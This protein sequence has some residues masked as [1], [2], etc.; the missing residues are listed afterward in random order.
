M[1]KLYHGRVSV[2]PR[3]GGIPTGRA[4]QG[5]DKPSPLPWTIPPTG[6]ESPAG[7]GQAVAPT[8]D[9]PAHGTRKPQQGED[10][11]SPLLWTKGLPSALHVI[12]R[13]SVHSRGDGLS[14]PWECH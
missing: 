8:M 9:D 6:R 10:K 5:E 13:D 4:R 1:L 3:Q 2:V 12:E 7:R 14:S 11:P